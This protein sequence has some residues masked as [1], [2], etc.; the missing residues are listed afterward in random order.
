[1]ASN[2]KRRVALI[3]NEKGGVGKSVFTRAL[4]DWLRTQGERVLAFD[5]D[6]SIG[7][8]IRVL[9]TREH[10]RGPVQDAGSR[11]RGRLLQWPQ[12]Q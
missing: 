4:V 12:R 6:G 1:M 7:A 9:G 3:A 10:G 2:G 11:G 5:A 8:T